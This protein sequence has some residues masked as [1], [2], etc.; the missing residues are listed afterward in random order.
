MFCGMAELEKSGD[1]N[2]KDPDSKLTTLKIAKKN[3]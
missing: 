3:Q 2:I 1:D